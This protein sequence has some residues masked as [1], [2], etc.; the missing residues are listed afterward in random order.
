MARFLVWSDLHDEF[1]EGF[2]L[3]DLS[4]PVDGVLIAG[5]T[6]TM[7]R[8]LEIPARAARKYG[9][10]VV[11]IWGNHEPYG[12]VWSELLVEE[13]RQ[14]AV[15]RAEGL[16]IRVLHGA[17]TEVA[18]VRIIGAPLWTDLKLYPELEELAYRVVTQ[19]LNDYHN[20]SM[21]PGKLMTGEDM[22]ALHK[23]DKAA[24]FDALRRPFSG[25]TLVMTHHLPI[26]KLVHPGRTI[27]RAE[28]RAMNAGFASDLW[29]EIKQF[30]I[31]SW[32]CGHSH[33]N[34]NRVGDGDHG[35]IHFVMNARGYPGEG[36]PFDPAYVLSTDID[37]PGLPKPPHK[38][39]SVRPAPDETYF[40]LEIVNDRC[41][42]QADIAKLPFYDF[43]RQSSLGS[44]HPMDRET[45]EP[46][47]WLHD[48]ES[49]CRMFILTGRHRLMK[50][51]CKR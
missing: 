29:D 41:V 45:G 15:F 1:W 42:R 40:G 10:P 47:V 11:V 26:S 21:S 43:W 16:D 4:A 13:E 51:D 17:A 23:Q 50:D 48:W 28:K 6:H 32:I 2:D 7:G 39:K 24:V 19:G 9:C 14:L 38:A 18:G 8:H 49:F 5:D 35:S 22:L 36:T 30:D 34:Q 46:L 44:G 33:D 12:S 27:G 37:G 3:P 20:I 31:H 25:T